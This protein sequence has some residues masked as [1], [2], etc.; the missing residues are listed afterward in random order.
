LDNGD[1]IE[2][3]LDRIAEQVSRVEVMLRE[4]LQQPDVAGARTMD[5]NQAAEYLGM[6]RG[7]V[8]QGLPREP[9]YF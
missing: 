4:L 8:A 2:I 6:T 1:T 9:D 5:A 7:K 3:K